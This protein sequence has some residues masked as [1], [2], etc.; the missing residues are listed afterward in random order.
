M[1][2]HGDAQ[3]LTYGAV[4]AAKKFI[5]YKEGVKDLTGSYCKNMQ[6]PKAL[7]VVLIMWSV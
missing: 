6:M 7:E 2:Y 4:S 3:E 1:I 5:L